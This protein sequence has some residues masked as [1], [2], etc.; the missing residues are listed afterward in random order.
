MKE[1]SPWRIRRMVEPEHVQTNFGYAAQPDE[2]HLAEYWNI[3]VKHRRVVII[4]LIIGIGLGTYFPFSATKLYT[5]SSSIKIEPQNPQV[6]GVGSLQPLD[7]SQFGGQYDYYQTQFALLRSRRLA[8]TVIAD[9]GLESNNSFTGTQIVSPNPLDHV[10]FWMSRIAGHISYYT[11]S[12]FKSKRQADTTDPDNPLA[13]AVN[14]EIELNIDRR[15]ISRYLGFIKIAPIEKTRLVRIEF[16]TPDPTLSQALA[17]AHVE[18]FMRM[19]LESRFTLTKEAREFLDKKMV[20]IREKLERSEGALNSFRRTHGVIS[21]EKGENIVVDRL[22]ELNRQLTAARAQRIEA[23][24]L[25]RTV[26]DKNYQDLA[27]V[28][29]QGLVAQLKGNVATLEADKARL[30]TIFKADHPRIREVSQEIVAARQAL[31]NEI[32]SVVRTIQSNYA[33]ALA[34]ERALQ[35]EADKQQLNAL[36]VKELGVEFTVL[37]GE[38]NA[39]RTLYESVLKR[40]SE[41]SLASDVAVSNVQIAERADK[42]VTPSAPKA[43]LYLMGSII[44]SLF[45]GIGLAFVREYFDS[46]VATPDDVRRAVGLPT[47]GVVPHLKYLD[48]GIYK[49]DIQSSRSNGSSELLPGKPVR[50]ELITSHSPVSILNESYR[51]IRT[52]LLL[53]QANNP[54]QVV[55]LSSAAPNEGKTTTTLNLAIAL[56]HDGYPV[57]VIDADLRKGCCHARLGLRNN[58]GLS[59][60]L[61]GSLSLKEGI[62][63]TF[64]DGL[65]L[66]SRGI[67]PPNPTE[68]LGSRKM[69]EL[70]EEVRQGFK[71]ILIDSPP[72]VAVS[73]A[74]VLSVMSDGVLLVFDGEKT[75]TPSAQKAVERLDLVHANFLG[76]VLNGVNLNDPHYSYYKTYSSY[77]A[78]EPNRDG[79]TERNGNVAQKYGSRLFRNMTKIGRLWNVK[80]RP[81]KEVVDY[82]DAEFLNTEAATGVESGSRNSSVKDRSEADN[83]LWAASDTARVASEPLTLSQEPLS[84]LVEVLTRIVGPVAPLLVR[85][86]IAA[87]GESHFAFPRDR[88]GELVKLIELEITPEE[89]ERFKA[90]MP[91][92]FQAFSNH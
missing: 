24:S 67:I 21:V 69:R 49:A 45:L 43:S 10:V 11:A 56:A 44:S 23:E 51:A 86:Q 22:L 2:V 48:R 70:L 88:T 53:S 60:V 90:S 30:S 73:D 15:L 78:Y 13:K 64:V 36:A 26:E 82:A 76:A 84:S 55:L 18:A 7:S 3:L 62:Q 66:L 57:L 50:K 75:S 20:E 14:G 65:S 58:R 9:L 80:D 87:L 41:T 72:A 74:A 83:S 91:K 46:R 29:K 31:I 1:I 77:Y 81:S 89:L 39:D 25:H 16:T 71:F 5:A 85:E 79:D 33:A 59:N 35:V 92:E 40:L 63:P 4:F 19:T 34:K 28:M 12:L 27:E 42:P 61:T 17:N 38:V 52:S 37:Q 32:A 8:A 54:P 68:I 47:L 6:T